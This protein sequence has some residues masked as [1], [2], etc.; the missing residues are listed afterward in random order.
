MIRIFLTTTAMSVA[1]IG[2]AQAQT[3]ADVL[4]T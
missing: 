3:A 2:T 1:V 4:N